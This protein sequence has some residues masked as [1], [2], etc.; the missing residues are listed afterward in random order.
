MPYRKY[1][2]LTVEER[3]HFID[4]IKNN[5][6][7]INTKA[8]R[9]V[10]IEHYIPL[11]LSISRKLSQQYK[12]YQR[13]D[14]LISTGLLT[15]VKCVK[16]I[17]LLPEISAENFPKYV[18]KSVSL[19]IRKFIVKELIYRAKF[20]SLQCKQNIRAAFRKTQ[21][22]DPLQVLIIKEVIKNE[23]QTT[24]EQ[25]II[26]SLMEG[27]NDLKSLSKRCSL[28]VSRVSTIKSELL[29]RLAGALNDL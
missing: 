13:H 2:Q 5:K 18:N 29:E 12:K 20:E 26:D 21:E 27:V 9:H 3:E 19:N 7:D 23:I 25:T 14:D 11:V 16:R 4:Y 15:L 24:V 8:A 17:P 22:S 1:L 28:S 10:V 6:D